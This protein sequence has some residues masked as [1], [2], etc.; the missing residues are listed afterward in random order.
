[1]TFG[2]SDRPLRLDI[3]A[4]R[5]DVQI[6]LHGRRQA[7]RV[8]REDA[9][10]KSQH[11][12]DG[13]VDIERESGRSRRHQAA[14]RLVGHGDRCGQLR[15]L[16]QRQLPHSV[17]RMVHEE[18]A[19][20]FR[21]REL[22]TIAP[23]QKRYDRRASHRS[24]GDQLSHHSTSEYIARPPTRGGPLRKWVLLSFWGI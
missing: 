17:F 12:I 16:T 23:R 13:H 6:E 1:M 8:E 3:P 21:R 22:P 15:T 10:G 18:I 2:R 19:R 9:D 24:D 14:A 11:R 20:W 7:G 4:A 5:V